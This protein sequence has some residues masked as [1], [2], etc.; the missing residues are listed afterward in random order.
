MPQP[1]SGQVHVDRPLT[2]ISTAYIQSA[3]AFVADKVFPVVP[4]QKQ[5]DLYFKYSR[6]DFYRSVAK[7]RAPSSESAGGG[8]SL[9]TDSYSC[10][11]IAVHKDVDE[12][13]RANS[14]DPLNADRDAAIWVTQ[15]MLLKREIDWAT[16]YFATGIWGTAGSTDQTGV[17]GSPSTNEFKQ[18]NDEASTPID[19]ITARANAILTATGVLP[20][21]LMTSYAVYLKIKNHPD[22]L[23]RIKYSYP[24]MQPAQITPQMIAAVLDLDRLLIAKAVQNTSKEGNATQTIA[25]ILGKAALLAYAAPSPGLMT[26]SAGYTFA[27]T[28]LLGAGAAGSRIERFPMVHLKADRIE[29]EMAYDQKVVASEL[30]CYFA[31]AIA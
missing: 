8:Y 7:V 19:D 17:S 3:D 30:G 29:G 13:T 11:P 6:D 10:I 14:D 31:A 15:Q 23:D 18:W 9:T 25:A 12:Q 28:G 2:N 16:K 22:M 21:L 20:N 24:G 4:V 1:H 26:P 5:S 27:W